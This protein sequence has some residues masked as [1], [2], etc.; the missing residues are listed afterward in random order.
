MKYSRAWVLWGALALTCSHV[1]MGSASAAGELVVADGIKVT[2]EYTL[3]LPDKS[4]ADTNVGQDPISF[5]Q[6]ANQILPGLEKGLNGMKAGQKKQIHISAAEGFGAYDPKAQVTVEKSQ[7]PE[8]VKAGTMLRAPDGRAIKVLEV[9][10]KAVVL[11]L[12][13]PL[14]G[15]DLLFDV[16]VLKLEKE[17]EAGKESMPKS[18]TPAP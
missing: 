9:T 13:H 10:E 16:H 12:N 4:V 11:D 2:L 6:G 15:K 17:Q 7:V 14:A 5:V 18:G 3:T 8:N 1:W